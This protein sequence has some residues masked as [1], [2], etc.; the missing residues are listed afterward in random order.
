MYKI[1]KELKDG[2][3]TYLANSIVPAKDAIQIINQLNSL[4]IIE[5]PV[6]EEVK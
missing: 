6:K 4:P 2:I 5:T 3:V 1:S